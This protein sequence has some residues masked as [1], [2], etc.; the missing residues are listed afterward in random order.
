MAVHKSDQIANEKATPRVMVK[1][2][3]RHGRRRVAYFSFTVPTGGAAVNDTVE[4]AKVPAGARILDG[5][6]AFEAMSTGAGDAGIQ[7]GDGTTAAKYLGTTS[8]DAAGTADFAHT[9]ALGYGEEL[10]SELTLTATVMTEAWAAGQKL[11][12]AIE[13]ALD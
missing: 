11:L 9:V 12:G 4:L 8:V 7:L 6:I 13:Y 5:R 10:A 1:P 2:S 3:E